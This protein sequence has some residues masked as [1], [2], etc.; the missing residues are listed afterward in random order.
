MNIYLGTNGLGG[1][2]GRSTDEMI[3]SEAADEMEE[4]NE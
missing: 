2:K 4:K 3:I 1:R